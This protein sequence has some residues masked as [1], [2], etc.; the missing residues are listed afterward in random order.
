MTLNIIPI[1]LSRLVCFVGLKVSDRSLLLVQL[2]LRCADLYT[3]LVHQTLLLIKP[4]LDKV[5]YFGFQAC[6]E[7]SQIERRGRQER[8]L[9]INIPSLL[10]FHIK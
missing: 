3:N 8:R 4:G 7:N 6:E 1:L 10:P 9:E 2:N 5:A